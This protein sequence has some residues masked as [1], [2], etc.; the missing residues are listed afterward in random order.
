MRTQG[1]A[2]F[3]ADTKYSS[4]L[5]F[6]SFSYCLNKIKF[7]QRKKKN[8]RDKHLNNH[9][10]DHHRIKEHKNQ[11]G[12]F[13]KCICYNRRSWKKKKKKKAVK[14]RHAGAL[15]LSATQ[16]SNKVR[17]DCFVLSPTKT[18][19]TWKRLEITVWSYGMYPK[20]V[21]MTKNWDFL[22]FHTSTNPLS[23]PTQAHPPAE[24]VR[25]LIKGQSAAKVYF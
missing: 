11:D 10:S 3:D 7:A 14:G 15:R 4:L 1:Y 17:Q 25:S 5:L 8:H 21:L 22:F 13:A 18:F 16:Y 9:N 23:P 24:Q 20:W 2:A 6:F 19:H 12:L